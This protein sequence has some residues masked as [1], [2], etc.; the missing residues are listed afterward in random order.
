MPQ[1][2]EIAGK[3]TEHVNEVR[4]EHREFQKAAPHPTTS[5]EDAWKQF[6]KLRESS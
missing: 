4:K 3:A 2:H 5:K 1:I 6:E